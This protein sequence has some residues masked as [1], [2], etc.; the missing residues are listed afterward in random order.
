M[1][2]LHGNL[3]SEDLPVSAYFDI[4]LGSFESVFGKHN[5]DQIKEIM[6]EKIEA[7]YA[8]E[9][10]MD[11]RTFYSIY[12]DCVEYFTVA[13]VDQGLI[14]TYTR[15]S[16]IA[17][18]RRLR[19]YFGVPEVPA[20][21]M[22]A[23]LTVDLVPNPKVCNIVLMNKIW[24]NQWKT[25]NPQIYDEFIR[26]MQRYWEPRLQVCHNLDPWKTLKQLILNES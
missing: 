9:D 1:G 12:N 2:L 14:T 20:F 15:D 8:G 5:M 16:I 26:H 18:A 3:I 25:V 22:Y 10:F 4:G 24:E 11:P 19:P 13:L 23:E 17:T 21:Y 7:D 6:F